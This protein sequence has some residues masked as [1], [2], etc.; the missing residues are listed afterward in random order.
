MRRTGLI[1]GAVVLIA[2]SFVGV[3]FASESYVISDYK[4]ASQ[5]GPATIAN[6]DYNWTSAPNNPNVVYIAVWAPQPYRKYIEEALVTVV[7]KHGLKPVVT[8]NF[9]RYDLKGRLVLFYS[10]SVGWGRGV[11]YKEVSLSGILYYSYAGD[12]KSAIETIN[13]GL[14]FSETQISNSANKFC[15]ASRKRMVGL[16]IV[17]QTCDVAYWWNLKAEVGKLSR[18]N[19]YEMIADEIASQLDQFLKSP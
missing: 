16:R 8:E 14:N 10:P 15:Q 5:T 4:G 1:L 6:H 18:T 13:N 11:L 3:A 2:L 12:A 19:P 17:N 7:K 9:T